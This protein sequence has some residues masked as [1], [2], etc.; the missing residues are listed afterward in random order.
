MD[1]VANF[2]GSVGGFGGGRLVRGVNCV[3]G[4]MGGLGFVLG[5]LV[6]IARLGII[7]KF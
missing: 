5:L 1:T 3:A 4:G 2:S 7:S 6:N